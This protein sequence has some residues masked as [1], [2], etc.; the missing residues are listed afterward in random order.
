[1]IVG[2]KVQLSTRFLSK[3]KDIEEDIDLDEEIEVPRWDFSNLITDQMHTVDEVLQKKA[4]HKKLK[5]ERD[6]E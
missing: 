3:C 1:M 4:K 2:L 5:E 6:K